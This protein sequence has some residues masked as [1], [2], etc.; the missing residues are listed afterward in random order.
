MSIESEE[1]FT[2]DV[3]NRREKF[4]INR[5]GQLHIKFITHLSCSVETFITNVILQEDCIKSPGFLF[6]W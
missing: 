3:L 2:F 4:R 6:S 1:A 5:S